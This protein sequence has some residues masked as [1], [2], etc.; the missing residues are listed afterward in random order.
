MRG[1]LQEDRGGSLARIANDAIKTLVAAMNSDGAP[2]AARIAAAN[3]IL[4]RG[5]GKT[6]E[7]VDMNVRATLED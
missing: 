2:W 1:T 6:K 5:W 3:G 7:T 4:D